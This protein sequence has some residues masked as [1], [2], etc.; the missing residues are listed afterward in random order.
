MDQD[1]DLRRG[2]TG[3]LRE[4]ADKGGANTFKADVSTAAGTFF[5]AVTVRVLN[6]FGDGI[7][8]AVVNLSTAD[9]VGGAGIAGGLATPATTGPGGTLTFTPAA[10]TSAGTLKLLASAS[11]ANGP[12]EPAVVSLTVTAGPVTNVAVVSGAIRN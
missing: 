4:D 9:S 1:T 7:E 6:P 11:N 12:T 2:S 3:H 5:P 10:N 8:G